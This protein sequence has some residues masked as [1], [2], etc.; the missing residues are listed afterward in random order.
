MSWQGYVLH[1]APSPPAHNTPPQVHYTGTLTNGQKF[2]SSRDRNDT[3]KFKIGVGQASCNLQSC[4]TYAW[5]HWDATS[6]P[7]GRC[8]RCRLAWV[9]RRLSAV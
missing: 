9:F 6:Y 5:L 1:R 4:C 2:D 7:R 3:F 8:R